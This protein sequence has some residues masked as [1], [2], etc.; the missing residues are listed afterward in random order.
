MQHCINLK[1]KGKHNLSIYP[2]KNKETLDEDYLSTINKLTF[3]YKNSLDYQ[4][5]SSKVKIYEKENNK[6]EFE[7][8]FNEL[9]DNWEF[10]R[11]YFEKEKRRDDLERMLDL[12]E[13]ILINEE[14]N[15]NKYQ[16]LTLS[17]RNISRL[18][19][20]KKYMCGKAYNTFLEQRDEN[21]GEEN[22]REFY[23][24]E[25]LYQINLKYRDQL[26]NLH[27]NVI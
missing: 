19:A 21:M 22:Q 24:L 20:C 13:Q 6:N 12:Y 4:S 26:L 25:S 1:I 7:I 16:Q 11:N 10:N 5:F 15:I 2:I 9:L 18:E 8:I 27:R 23:D 3:V 14:L 17:N